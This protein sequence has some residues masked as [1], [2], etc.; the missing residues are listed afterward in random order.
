MIRF[1]FILFVLG[2]LGHAVLGSAFVNRVHAWSLPRWIIHSLTIF[3]GVVGGLI[4]LLIGLDY[5]IWGPTALPWTGWRIVI[6]GYLVACSAVGVAAI[7]EHIR[8]SRDSRPPAALIADQSTT[9]DMATVLP[10]R[11]LASGL[12]SLLSRLPGNQVLQ[13]AVTKK[14]A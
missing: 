7:A 6:L 10:E 9:I 12:P 8:R 11:P 1:E 3:A 2:A 5:W 4:P 13:L 14:A